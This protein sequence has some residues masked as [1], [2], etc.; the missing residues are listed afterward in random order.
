M[1]PLPCLICVMNPLQEA[2][3]PLLQHLQPRKFSAAQMGW[4]PVRGGGRGESRQP[5][6]LPSG[7]R[8]KPSIFCYPL[9]SNPHPVQL[10]PGLHRLSKE[11][12]KEGRSAIFSA[13]PL[14]HSVRAGSAITACGPQAHSS[15]LDSCHLWLLLLCPPWPSVTT[16]GTHWQQFAS[17]R[18]PARLCLAQFYWPPPINNLVQPVG[19]SVTHSP[20]DPGGQVTSLHKIKCLHFHPLPTFTPQGYFHLNSNLSG[21]THYYPLRKET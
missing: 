7:S 9:P 5:I 4:R 11:V 10:H 21:V 15:P 1:Q 14:H 17:Q 19:V 3:Q 13:P 12:Q 20:C 16:L 2:V 6:L 8:W 18:L